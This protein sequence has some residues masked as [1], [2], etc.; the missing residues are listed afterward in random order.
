M[1][2]DVSGK[3]IPASLYMMKSQTLIRNIVKTQV[4][5]KDVFFRL[6]NELCEGNDTYMFVTAFIGII[7]LTT[8]D[9]QYVNAGH[10]PP[11]LKNDDKYDYLISNKNVVMGIYKNTEYKVE[12]IKLVSGNSILLY[13]DGV[14]EAENSKASFYGEKRHRDILNDTQSDPKHNL[15]IVLKQHYSKRPIIYLCCQLSR[16]LDVNL[17]R[18]CLD[19]H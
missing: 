18:N 8:G 13:T 12:T 16:I 17:K 7:D 1:I 15:Q 2:A 11:L 10:V 19:M 14:T 6:N 4:N 3:G 9:M 5:L